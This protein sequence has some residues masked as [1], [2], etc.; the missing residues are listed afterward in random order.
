M[1]DTYFQL[2]IASSTS[3]FHVMRI[4][5]FLLPFPPLLSKSLTGIDTHRRS[6]DVTF[7]AR[8]S[9]FESEP[10]SLPVFSWVFS[11][12]TNSSFPHTTV[13]QPANRRNEFILSVYI[14]CHK[15]WQIRAKKGGQEEKERETHFQNFSS[16]KFPQRETIPCNN[17]YDFLL[18]P[19]E[20]LFTNWT[21]T[22]ISLFA[23]FGQH[24]SSLN[25]PAKC[26]NSI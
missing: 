20:P 16:G 9:V 17:I 11:P 15:N 13:S 3:N 26:N 21:V 19:P 12:L 10:L 14:I 23:K 7:L 18:F 6:Q 4:S 24:L 8:L 2:S 25:F 5:V 1:G 22:F